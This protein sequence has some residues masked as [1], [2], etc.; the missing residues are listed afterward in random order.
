M[1]IYWSSSIFT[2]KIELSGK[3][4]FR[5]PQKSYSYLFSVENFQKFFVYHK[6]YQVK[7]RPF[8]KETLFLVFNHTNTSILR[9]KDQM[10]L[11]VLV[12]ESSNFD[13]QKQS[14]DQFKNVGFIAKYT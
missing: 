11:S 13:D 10:I 6:F 14:Y 9:W 3:L 7:N 2:A 12:F 1:L 8:K 4:Q 5:Y